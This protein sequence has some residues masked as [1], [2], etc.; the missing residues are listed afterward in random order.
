MI[1]KQYDIGDIRTLSWAM[2]RKHKTMQTIVQTKVPQ[3][4]QSEGTLH[5]FCGTL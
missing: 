2:R 4:W 5:Y 3:Y 1:I